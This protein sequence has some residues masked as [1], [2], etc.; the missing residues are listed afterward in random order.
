MWDTKPGEM[1]YDLNQLLSPKE[2]ALTQPGRLPSQGAA[3]SAGLKALQ[4][5]RASLPMLLPREGG[6]ERRQ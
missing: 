3:G 1:S 2:V 4:G 5:V 6:G